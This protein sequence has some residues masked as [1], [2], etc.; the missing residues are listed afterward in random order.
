MKYEQKPF[1]R[2]ER[3]KSAFRPATAL[4]PAAAKKQGCIYQR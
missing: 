3:R 1:S 4:P 2:P